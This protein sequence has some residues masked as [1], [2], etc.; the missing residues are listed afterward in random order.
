ML[1]GGLKKLVVFECMNVEKCPSLLASIMM[2]CTV[3]WK[4]WMLVIFYLGVLGSMMWMLSTWA[5]VTCVN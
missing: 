4:I 5:R 2:R 3:M 1:W